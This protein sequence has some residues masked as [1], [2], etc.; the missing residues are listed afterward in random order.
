M[1]KGGVHVKKK[2]AKKARRKGVKK[3]AVLR[4]RPSAKA[5]SK[6]SSRKRVS[7]K[8][9]K[10]LKEIGKITHYFPKVKA[11]VMKV[12]KGILSLGDEIHIKG[13]TTDFK[14]K[15]ASMQLD[16]VPLEKASAGQEIGIA[17]K[18]RVRQNDMVY[19]A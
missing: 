16:H 4:R 8:P 2:S 18:S 15:V 12:T 17:V 3:K 11:G 7:L 1:K 5:K 14:Q 19:R 13:H 10:V 9:K 6:V